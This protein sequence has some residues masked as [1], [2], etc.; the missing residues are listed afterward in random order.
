[1][2]FNNEEE[3]LKNKNR[4]EE[5]VNF[6][7]NVNLLNILDET[8]IFSDDKKTNNY[9]TINNIDNKSESLICYLM[10]IHYMDAN[11]DPYA[12]NDDRHS[13][14]LETN[15]PEINEKIQVNDWREAG[16]YEEV[17]WNFWDVSDYIKN[18]KDF[19]SDYIISDEYESAIKTIWD[20]IST[21]VEKLHKDVKLKDMACNNII[22]KYS[23]I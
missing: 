23:K 20:E 17:E 14:V 8:D 2:I 7:K 6:I 13:L 11:D 18:L 3:K 16:E 5:I 21:R 10:V 22:D 9:F 12:P 1:M 19:L 4:I 15:N